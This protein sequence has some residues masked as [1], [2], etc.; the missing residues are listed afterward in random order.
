VKR[1]LLLLLALVNALAAC[2]PGDPRCARLPGGGAYCLQPTAA[3]PPF[4]VQQKLEIVFSGRRETM[5]VELEVDAD[6]MRFAGLTPFGHKLVQASFDNREVS[7][8]VQPDKRLDPALLLAMLQLALWP[9]ERVRAGLSDA[10]ALEERAGQR[11]ILD[12]GNLVMEVDYTGDR[13]ASGDMRIVFPAAEIEITVT[14]LD[15]ERTK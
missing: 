12:N 6:G 2:S 5:I 4:D 8:Q 11:R 14:T 1:I 13:L 3:V 7:A 10:L 9:A 15:T